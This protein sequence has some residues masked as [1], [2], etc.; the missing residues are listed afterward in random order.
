M[1]NI[2]LNF[3]EFQDSINQLRDMEIEMSSISKV[4][5]QLKQKNIDLKQKLVENNL[6]VYFLN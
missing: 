1:A 4:I 3:D 2:A 5:K 6:K